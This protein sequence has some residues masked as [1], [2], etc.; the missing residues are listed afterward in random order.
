MVFATLD[1]KMSLIDFPNTNK[2]ILTCNVL[3]SLLIPIE[4]I[5]SFNSSLE[6]LFSADFLLLVHD[7]SNENIENQANVVINTLIEIGFSKEDLN[8]KIINIFNKS[9]LNSNIPE[10]NTYNKNKFIKTSAIKAS[11][12]NSLKK[13]IEDEIEGDIFTLDFFIPISSPNI[14]SWLFKNSSVL[15]ETN[16]NI[17]FDGRKLRVNISSYQLNIFKSNYPNVNINRV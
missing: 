11:G 1:T 8:K 6:E 10:L 4:L 3:E 9:D 2:V 5:S 13:Y 12:L 14:C 16:K 15:S 7:L 17:D